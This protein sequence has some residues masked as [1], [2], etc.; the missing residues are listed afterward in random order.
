[1]PS[2]RWSVEFY[3]PTFHDRR[4]VGKRYPGNDANVGYSFEELLFAHC[5]VSV[6]GKPFNE[7]A[8]VDP[9]QKIQFFSYDDVQFAIG[10]FLSMFTLD[11]DQAA[12]AR[13]YGSELKLNRSGS[14]PVPKEMLPSQSA[15]FTFR[16]PSFADRQNA[17]R[18]YPRETN[19]GY[20]LEELLF[21]SMIDSIN[22]EPVARS[23][24]PVE[25]L[26]DFAMVDVQFGLAVFLQIAT[27]DPDEASSV[28][29][30]LGKRLKGGSTNGT[31]PTSKSRMKS[32]PSATTAS[33]AAANT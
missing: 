31:S 11:R 25:L 29:R 9:I 22:G 21:A 18:R 24:Q 15:G 5:L 2:R 17:S 30:D 27:I 10:V 12:A 4:E 16:E 3:E 7:Q 13:R 14:F 20:T 32:A 26:D 19:P 28:I 33:A 1:M 23:A 8:V 6:D